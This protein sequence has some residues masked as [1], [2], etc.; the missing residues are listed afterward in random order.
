MEEEELRRLYVEK[1][2]SQ[3]EVANELETGRW[4]VRK[5][6]KKYDITSHS[7]GGKSQTAKWKDR[8]WLSE[9]YHSENMSVREIADLCDC[10]T[11]AIHNQMKSLNVRRRSPTHQRHVADL[12]TRKDGY[13]VWKPGLDGDVATVYHHRLLA[14]SEFGLESLEGMEV[15][16]K[17]EVK[18]DNRR[19]NLE[20]M[21]PSEHMS[22]HNN[23]RNGGS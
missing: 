17:N 1:G 8:E 12:R 14:V 7:K 22:H 23:T 3:Q 16:H 11:M 9:K 18:W 15:H 6:I 5:A 20:L 19:E 2:L 4:Q 10:T 21:T 13:E